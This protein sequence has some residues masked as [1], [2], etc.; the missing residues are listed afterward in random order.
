M[1]TVLAKVSKKEII[2]NREQF[3]IVFQATSFC[4]RQELAF[5]GHSETDDEG[6]FKE[7]V[8][9]IVAHANE[10]VKSNFERRYGHYYSHDYQNE[11]IALLSSEVR[12]DISMKIIEAKYFAVLADET[13][14]VS[15]KE[16]FSIKVRYY[17]LS[18]QQLATCGGYWLFPFE[19]TDCIII[20]PVY[21]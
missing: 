2:T 14:D 16:Q 15:G 12:V 13:K 5:R 21:Y 1:N 3:K 7:V 11:F 18:A 17:D 6:N 19:I 8:K 9:A 4:A 10:D 20:S